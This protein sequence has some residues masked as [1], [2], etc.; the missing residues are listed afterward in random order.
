[1]VKYSMNACAPRGLGAP[2][3]LAQLAGRVRRARR[4]PLPLPPPPLPLLQFM[5]A[6]LATLL[7]D[8]ASGTTRETPRMDVRCEKEPCEKE[9]AFHS[10]DV[11]R[12][13]GAPRV[14]ARNVAPAVCAPTPD[15]T[16]HG[17]RVHQWA[18]LRKLADEECRDVYARGVYARAK[19]ARS[20][21]RSQPSNRRRLAS[22]TR[23]SPNALD[24]GPYFNAGS[25]VGMGGR[26]RI[27]AHNVTKG[28]N[29]TNF[30]AWGAFRLN[31]GMCG[32]EQYLLEKRAMCRMARVAEPC[33]SPDA[34]GVRRAN[35][36]PQLLAWDDD[37]L[38]LVVTND[39]CSLL[40]QETGDRPDSL[41]AEMLRAW[42]PC[43]N[44]MIC[45]RQISPPGAC[46]H[47][48]KPLSNESFQEQLD[49][50]ASQLRRANATHLDANCKNIFVRPNGRMTLG[51]L[52]M[53]E[54]DGIP[55]LNA[56]GRR[57]TQR[58][59]AQQIK[60]KL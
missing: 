7:V 38:T 23:G 21:E 44:H 24:D 26:L 27:T 18:A 36:F 1:M 30:R 22:Y 53:S 45:A 20:G 9:L 25:N 39:G 8:V 12:S 33:G 10:R 60:G 15:C 28:F 47:G 54:I 14:C 41:P 34:H 59:H 40:R 52:D 17:N 58:F 56:Y 31:G 3:H 6:L 37:S 55:A 50:T 11:S 43:H 16:F 13:M 35:F 42:N 49:C 32:W 29:G 19:E 2:A 51:D 57:F 5:S 48:W 4:W 46:G